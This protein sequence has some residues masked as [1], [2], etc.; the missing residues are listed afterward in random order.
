VCWPFDKAAAYEYGQIFAG[1]KRLGR[2]IQQVDMMIAAIARI[3]GNCTV[4]SGDN[5]LLAVPGLSVENWA[6]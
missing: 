5:D 4:V 1:L 2:P 6:R 3:L